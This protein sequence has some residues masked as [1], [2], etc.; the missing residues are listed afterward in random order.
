MAFEENPIIDEASKNSE[1]SE[2]ALRSFFTR[3]N[4][5]ILRQESPDY[6]VDFNCEVANSDSPTGKLFAIQL[7]SKENLTFVYDNNNCQF[8]SFPFKTSRLGYL[9]RRQPMFGI[10]ALYDNQNRVVYFDYIEDIIARLN[11]E[12]GNDEWKA[13]EFVNIWIPKSNVL[14]DSAINILHSKM[15]NRAKQIDALITAYGQSFQIPSVKQLSGFS[16]T[17]FLTIED[18][19]QFGLGFAYKFEFELLYRSLDKLSLAEIIRSL[20]LLHLAA[21]VNTERGRTTEAEYYLRK[22]V[23]RQAEYSTEEFQSIVFLKIRVDT[24]LGNISE[25]QCLELLQGLEQEIV[26]KQ[27]LLMLKLNILNLK[28]RLADVRDNAF[29]ELIEEINSFFQYIDTSEIEKTQ[30]ILLSLYNCESLSSVLTLY[31]IYKISQFKI[32]EAFGTPVKKTDTIHWILKMTEFYKAVDQRIADAIDLAEKSAIIVP[33]AKALFL[34][35]IVI[36]NFISS[37][38]ILREELPFVSE[39]AVTLDKAKRCA[40]A[41]YVMH[42]KAGMTYDAYCSLLVLYDVQR[43]INVLVNKNENSD[44]SRLLARIRSY[45]EAHDIYENFYSSVDSLLEKL[46]TKE[47]R[48]LAD[49]TNDELLEDATIMANANGFDENQK[50]NLFNDM[51]AHQIFEKHCKGKGMLLRHNLLYSDPNY[52]YRW[53]PT[54]SIISAVSGIEYGTSRDI[55]QLLQE[56]GIDASDAK[57]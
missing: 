35:A 32:K 47:E 11:D 42:D 44:N 7:K 37:L 18:L 25:T 2:I 1:E 14:D 56:V 22:A 45:K 6:G 8:V 29:P 38:L 53:P 26:G 5:F 30:K 24:A 21:L 10:I 52:T 48:S 19:N 49:K 4:G 51:K 50:M 55:Y 34:R 57:E 31:N 54:Y 40:E 20:P 43:L 46:N 16:N 41:S 9:F 33:Y 36:K 39:A 23:Q 13:N 17:A 12:R 3:R 27:N 28:V 15:L